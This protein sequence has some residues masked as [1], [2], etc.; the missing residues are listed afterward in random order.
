[1]VRKPVSNGPLPQRGQRQ[2]R[3]VERVLRRGYSGSVTMGVLTC[4]RNGC[5][6]VGAPPQ[7]GP[8]VAGTPLGVRRSSPMTDPLGRAL[9]ADIE[10]LV[11]AVLKA[12]SDHG[13]ALS[14]A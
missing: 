4:S 8:V 5:R 13:V 7:A 3:P 14:T 9:P 10:A 1:M 11:E 12:A 2:R 6:P